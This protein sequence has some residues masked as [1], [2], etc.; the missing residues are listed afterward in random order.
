MFYINIVLNFLDR[1]AAAII[2]SLCG[3]LLLFGVC[4]W[5]RNVY[6]KQNRQI[7]Q[8]TR[9]CCAHP[10]KT[11]LYASLLPEEYRRQ[12]RAYVNSG[13]AKPS[14]VFEFVPRR[15]RQCLLWLY[16]LSAL[17]LSL[18]IVVFAFDISKFGYLVVQ[19]TYLL[20]FALTVVAN[21]RI[22]ARNE[23][24]ARRLFG[25]LVAQLNLTA[26]CK[27]VTTDKAIEQ[28]R[29]LDKFPVDGQS[30]GKA[31]QILR[32]NSADERTVD[33]QRRLNLA[34]NKLLQ[35]YA[36]GAKHEPV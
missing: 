20:A 1:Y 28:L 4:N 36:N 5:A 11:S 32:D 9:L 24:E 14:L 19:I 8:C 35:A 34:L 2:P 13:A 33:E 15:K 31:A 6:R 12:W 18:Y 3:V 10:E 7:V 29:K 21:K 26:D 25:R 16:V 22:A 17:A 23:R 27:Q 30:V